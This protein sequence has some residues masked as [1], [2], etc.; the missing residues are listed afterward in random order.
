[1]WSEEENSDYNERKQLGEEDDLE[2]REMKS[3]TGDNRF[4]V[5][6]EFS[7]SQKDDTSEAESE[8]ENLEHESDSESDGGDSDAERENAEA[9][10]P[11]VK[12][13]T[14]EKLAKFQAKLAKTGVCFMSRIPPFMKH[15][16]L[17]SILSKY[18]E[19]G[20]IYLNPEDPKVTARRKKYKKNRR[21]NFVEGWIEFMDKKTARQVAELLNNTNFGGKKR[22]R[23]YDD[24]WNIKYLPK[25]KWNHLTEQLAYEKKVKEQKLRAEMAQAKRENKLYLKNVEKAKMIEAISEKKKRKGEQ[26]ES[27][28]NRQFK[29]RKVQ[30]EP[31]KATLKTS[32]FTN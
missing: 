6:S 26:M 18:G 9:L 13:L 29:Q 28:V 10:K 30:Q 20:R 21:Q 3:R 8:E 24:I 5:D 25:F 12:P 4:E 2:E 19:I 27:K 7:E 31:K 1:M 14:A 23:Y 16:K 15:T 32:I 22:S 11:D 17:R